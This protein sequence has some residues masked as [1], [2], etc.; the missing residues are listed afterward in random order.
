MQQFFYFTSFLF[1]TPQSY[2][3][4]VMVVDSFSFYYYYYYYSQQSKFYRSILN[5][6]FR[7]SVSTL[8][9]ANLLFFISRKRNI[10]TTKK[11][12]QTERNGVGTLK[13][14]L[15]AALHCTA[16]QDDRTSRLFRISKIIIIQLF[17]IGFL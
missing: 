16:L 7:Y 9:E 14:S 12:H 5:I 8:I 2:L 13:T 6:S 4:V 15:S 17:L 11:R 1:Q 3:T 10:S